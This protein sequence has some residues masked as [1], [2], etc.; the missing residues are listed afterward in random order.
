MAS[1]G[2]QAPACLLA[3][4]GLPGAG[5]STLCRALVA[6]VAALQR[7]QCTCVCFDAIERSFAADQQPGAEFDAARWKARAVQQPLRTRAALRPALAA[8]RSWRVRRR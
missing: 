7:L 1:Q 5:K 4:C 3:L 2:Q 8:H 6:H